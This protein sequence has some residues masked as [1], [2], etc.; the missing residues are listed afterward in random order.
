LSR[1]PA[2]GEEEQAEGDLRD[3]QCL[4]EGEGVCHGWSGGVATATGQQC[5]QRRHDA[6]GDDQECKQSMH[7]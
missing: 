6:Y 7:R 3:D 4:R 5:E 1:V 2:V